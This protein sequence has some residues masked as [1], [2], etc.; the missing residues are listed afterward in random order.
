MKLLR[1]RRLILVCLILVWVVGMTYFLTH[2]SGKDED[3][4]QYED[5]LSL[6]LL[7]KNQDADDIRLKQDTKRSQDQ[8]KDKRSI[9][10]KA[11]V[12]DVEYIY[13]ARKISD[14]DPVA[15]MSKNGFKEGEDA[16]ARNAYNLKVSD[17]VAFDRQ[18]P[19]V[20]DPECQKTVWPDDL[21]TTSVIICFHNEGR[22]A[23]L[24]T[25]VSTINKSPPK[26]LKEIILVDDFSDDPEDGKELLRLPKV[27]L[28]R[29]QKREGLI[30]SRVKGADIAKGEVL[31][32][33]DS[34]CECSKNWLEPL[35]LRIKENPKTVVSPIIDVINMDTFEYLGSSSDL[36]GGFGWNLNFKWDFLPARIISERQG[37]PTMPIKTPVIAGG[38]FSIGKEWFATLGKYDMMMDVWGG[39][40]LEISFRTWQC[41]GTM[42]IIPCSRVGHVFRNRHPYKFPGGS[43]NI[44]QKNT[45]RAVE[46]WMDEYKKYYYAAVP[47]AKNTPYGNIE[48]RLELRKK[49]KCKPFKW[50][51]QNVYPELKVP[52]DDDTKAFG[53]IKQGSQCI[54]TLGHLTGQN[55]GLYECHGGGGNQMWSLTKSSL[56]KHESACLTASSTNSQEAPL[57]QECNDN[58]MLQHWEYEKDINRLRHKKSGLCLDSDKVKENGLI[59]NTCSDNYSQHWAFEVSL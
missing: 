51:V 18:V 22:S 46:V 8:E 31:T 28:I 59:L 10:N 40:N 16:Y 24:R 26:L 12:V 43:M 34:H 11:D 25:V 6:S 56:L 55:V 37:K 23:L 27:K 38:L 41:G 52:H 39:E 7:R 57:L 30:R 48:Q 29:N 54:D 3:S 45:R 44:F 9:L 50:F 19:E 47:Y 4:N 42:E 13:D 5:D 2:L 21:P 1:R 17:K 36:R 58:E 33:L 15:Y 35:L 49:L 32:F 20:R 53:E 14:L